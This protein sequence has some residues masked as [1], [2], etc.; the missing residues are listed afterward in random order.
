MVLQ[1]EASVLQREAGVLRREAGVLR[2]EAGVLQKEDSLLLREADA[3]QREVRSLPC[4]EVQRR[5][6]INR[7]GARARGVLQA[8]SAD[9][10]A[11]IRPP[12]DQA[13]NSS[14]RSRK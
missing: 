4:E 11:A 14:R 10:V 9:R 13:S 5:R 1:K 2:R 8:A 7:R 12:F 6:E 3:L